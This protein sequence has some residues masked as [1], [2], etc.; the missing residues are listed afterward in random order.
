MASIPQCQSDCSAFL[1]SL[2]CTV[3]DVSCFCSDTVNKG[4][5]SCFECALS[6]EPGN[7]TLQD[8]GNA[9]LKRVCLL[10][11]QS[12]HRSPHDLFF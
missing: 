4:V 8:Q 2:Q 9:Y 5:V 12:F 1:Q 7:Q 10:L 3:T 11:I 6:L